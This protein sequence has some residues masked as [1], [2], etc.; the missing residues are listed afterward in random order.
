[1]KPKIETQLYRMGMILLF[2]IIGI[3]AVKRITFPEFDI[4]NVM[5]PCVFHQ[6]T[7]YYCPGCG[8]TRS[9]IALLQGKILV[10]AVDFPMVV[11]CAAVYLW[12]LLSHTIE[13]ISRGR[14]L[15]GM[16]YHVG[17]IYATLPIVAVHCIVKNLFYIR[18]GMPPFL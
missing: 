10:S 5:K 1:M 16:P 18:T 6:L 3:T 2:L 7:G 9:V 4:R 13:K 14:L 12:F 11:Y 17:W 15:I 8:G